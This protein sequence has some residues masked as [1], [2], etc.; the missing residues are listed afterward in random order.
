MLTWFILSTSNIFSQVSQFLDYAY[1]PSFACPPNRPN[2]VLVFV[3]CFL[4]VVV[5]VV[6]NPFALDILTNSVNGYKS[7][8]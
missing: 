2:F 3:C 4:F 6:Y 8:L 7:H 5:V 1:L